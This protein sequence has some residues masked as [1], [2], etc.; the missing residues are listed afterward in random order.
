MNS[1]FLEV[2]CSDFS[3][4]LCCSFLTIQ[5]AVPNLLRHVNIYIRAEEDMVLQMWLDSSSYM[6]WPTWLVVMVDGTNRFSTSGSHLWS[7]SWRSSLAS[8]WRNCNID[9]IAYER[10]IDRIV[11]INTFKILSVGELDF[12]TYSRDG[13]YAILQMVDCNSLSLTIGCSD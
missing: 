8:F 4:D 10:N 13:E 1:F 9:T 7:I 3:T 6:P 2:I 5:F 12:F 11:R